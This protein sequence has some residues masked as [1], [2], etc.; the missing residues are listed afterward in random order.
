MY[1]IA[2]FENKKMKKTEDK[3]QR[4]KK[5]AQLIQIGAIGGGAKV[6]LDSLENETRETNRKFMDEQARIKGGSRV[7]GNMLL[8][9]MIV[10][11]IYQRNKAR[12]RSETSKVVDRSLDGALIGGYSALAS[13]IE[14]K[15]QIPKL[16]K[17]V[18]NLNNKLNERYKKEDVI[19]TKNLNKLKRKQN[20]INKLDTNPF[21]NAGK[22]FGTAAL[23]GAGVSNISRGMLDSESKKVVTNNK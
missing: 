13:G 6:G 20:F 21:D 23:I 8:P 7:L 12:N 11:N 14:G 1:N 2:D 17:E 9:S 22:K 4:D 10:G 5:V 18:D 3:K 16:E 19:N 15:K